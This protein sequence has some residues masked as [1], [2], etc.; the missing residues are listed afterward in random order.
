MDAVPDLKSLAAD[1]ASTDPVNRVR[2]HSVLN[3][4]GT[5]V[6]DL[7]HQAAKL[8]TE[9]LNRNAV[10][11]LLFWMMPPQMASVILRESLGPHCSDWIKWPLMV[12]VMFGV[13]VGATWLVAHPLNN[14]L[15]Q[16]TNT[17]KLLAVAL[18][19]AQKSDLRAIAPLVRV[20]NGQA[21]T[22]NN[23]QAAQEL[24]RLFSLTN[25]CPP[26]T[27]NKQ[28]RENLR[29]KVSNLY[30]TRKGIHLSYPRLDFS[31]ATADLLG[32]LMRIWAVSPDEKNRALVQRIADGKAIT[33]NQVLVREIAQTCLQATY[34]TGTVFVTRTQE[35]T[36]TANAATTSVIRVGR[37][38]SQ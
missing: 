7:L 6:N 4:A 9:R 30:V 27:L 1:L 25:A 34:D 2:A 11:V 14:Y 29:T 20:W 21:A 16:F 5:G 24:T 33:P 18:K 10:R 36:N 37:G 17:D 26:D 8:E 32:V 22:A 23:D 15:K 3:N 38:A 13:A 35:R 28:E 19:L 12:V 31:D